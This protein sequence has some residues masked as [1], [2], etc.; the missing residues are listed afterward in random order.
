MNREELEKIFCENLFL[1]KKNL[2]WLEKSYNKAKNINLN[3]EL[4][5][6]DL[7]VLETLS[8]RFGRTIDILINKVLRGLDLL[9]LEEI[10]RKLD[11][12]IRAEKRGFVDDYKTLIKMKDLLN[13]L[14]H[15]YI[16]ENLAEKFREIFEYTPKLFDIIERVRTYIR[17][18]GYC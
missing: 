14:V 6:D 17:K 15:E 9:E 2:N 12:V 13:E 1:L 4:S 11:I 5:E 8:N 7:E 16:Q 10:N 18:M 3:V